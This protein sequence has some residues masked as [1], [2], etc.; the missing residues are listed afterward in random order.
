MIDSCKRNT[1]QIRCTVARGT[2]FLSL[3]TQPM[4]KYGRRRTYTAVPSEWYPIPLELDPLSVHSIKVINFVQ[5]QSWQW[6][7]QGSESRDVD[8]VMQKA[9]TLRRGSQLGRERADLSEFVSVKLNEAGGHGNFADLMT[10]RNKSKHDNGYR[11]T[12]IFGG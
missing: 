11:M 4:S 6:S 2:A 10:D 5:S 3:D 12:L 9:F 8:F 1:Q 7:I